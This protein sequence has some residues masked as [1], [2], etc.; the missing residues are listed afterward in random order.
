MAEL[1]EPLTP[2]DCDLR[3]F[4]YMELDVR[5]LRDSRFA[6]QVCGDAFR[7]GVLL[8]CAAWHQVPAGSIPDDDIELAA[9]AGY[10]RFVKEWRKVRD[11]ALSQFVKC[12]DGRL[13]HETVCAKA[14]S[15][16]NGR[17]HHHY[18]R[19]RDRL[20]KTNKMREGKGLNPLPDMTF[21]EWNEQRLSK[22]IPM[23]RAEAF[24]GIPME[25][26]PEN[27]G[28][29]AEN[30]L[31]GRGKGN[32][33]GEGEGEKSLKAKAATAGASKPNA[34]DPPPA[35]PSDPIQSRAVELATLLRKRGAALQASDPRVHAW[36]SDG[37]TDAQVLTALETAQQR[38]HEAADPAPINAGYLDAIIRGGTAPPR[39][40]Q[41][42]P[43]SAR[44]ARIANYA[45]EAAAARGEAHDRSLAD[46]RRTVDV[47]ARV[48]A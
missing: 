40:Q 19:A 31:K 8:W 30:A 34:A 47:E 28:I 12:S 41:S 15:A 43:T 35:P 37:I 1:P 13:Y 10:G 32:G 5:T 22:G 26:A 2:P 36:A 17:L 46:D 39:S 24:H 42:R 3:D 25:S 21:E 7:A 27:H 14:L 48:V 29:P 16:W 38:R 45:A 44:E 33:E 6:A 11:E 23:E 18:D 4:Q 9:L 20:R